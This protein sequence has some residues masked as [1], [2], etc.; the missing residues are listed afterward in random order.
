M[1][2]KWDWPL[3]SPLRL[4]AQAVR[5]GWTPTPEKPLPPDSFDRQ[6]PLEQI[7]LIP[8]GCTKFRVSMFPVT[9]KALD[10]AD[11]GAKE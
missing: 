1:P 7:R 3:A 10:S 4:R 6:G 9:R 8:Y 5:I 11:A 2:G